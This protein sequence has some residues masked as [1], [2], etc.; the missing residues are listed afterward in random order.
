MSIPDQQD[1][2]LERLQSGLER[3]Q[4]N[5]GSVLVGVS[6]GAD[7]VSLLRGLIQLQTRRQTRSQ[8]ENAPES[9]LRIVAA[10]I[11]HQLRDDSGDDADW[12]GGLAAELGVPCRIELADVTGRVAE[13]G[14]SLEEAARS[15]RYGALTRIAQEEAC[16]AI[17]V[18]HTADDQAETVLHHLLRG[19]SVTGLGGMRWTRPVATGNGSGAGHDTIAGSDS[20][21][22][23]LIRP[24]LEIRRNEL[25]DWLHQIGQQFRTDSTNTDETLTRNRIRHRLLPLLERDFNPQV[26][27][28]LGT[29]AGHASEVSDLLAQLAQQRA[30]SAL[31]QISDTSIRIDCLALTDQPTIL[32]RE[33][34]LAIWRQAQWPLKRMGHR[35]WQAL[36]NLVRQNGGAVSLPGKTD[37][38]RRGQ[39]LVLTRSTD[40]TEHPR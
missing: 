28:A 15:T 29:L 26:R 20:C 36:A 2:F 6:G 10:H 13:T 18:A 24:M 7:S 8:K 39:I 19:T 40:Q 4:V 32:V 30:E 27:K 38:R 5:H 9:R 34:L 1:T 25:E 16:S 11:N 14:E 22:I 37:A 31:V 17:A 35:E 23:R 3:C 21:D 33:T 12:V